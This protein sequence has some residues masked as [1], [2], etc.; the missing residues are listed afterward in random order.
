MTKLPVKSP[1]GWS[2]SG[3]NIKLPSVELFG[4]RDGNM[5]GDANESAGCD[6]IFI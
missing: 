1:K 3:V 4:S 6:G 2:S 5:D